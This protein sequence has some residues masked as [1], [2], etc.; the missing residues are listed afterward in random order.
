ML[1]DRVC[2]SRSNDGHPNRPG[3][4][5]LGIDM[6]LN[7]LTG[8]KEIPDLISAPPVVLMVDD[9]AMVGEAMRRMLSTESDIRFH[10]CTNPLNAIEVANE[11]G[12]TV[13]LQ[14]LVMPD[15]D[16]MHMVAQ[17]RANA[18]TRDIPVIVLSSKEDPLIKRDAFTRGANDYLVKLPDPI[19]LIARVRAHSRSFQTQKELLLLQKKLEASNAVLRQ[20]STQ[21]GLTGLA[22]R[23]HFDDIVEREWRRCQRS[24]KQMSLIMIDIDGFKLYND[25]YGH[26]GGDD[27]L[28]MVA[29]ALK[30]G[31]L[32]GGD[33]VARYG[34]EEFAI[35]LPETDTQGAA[36]VGERLREGVEDLHLSH[37]KSPCSDHVTI[38]VGVATCTPSLKTAPERLIQEADRALYQAKRNGRNRVITKE[39]KP[40][41]ESAEAA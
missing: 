6:N 41:V 28:R 11:V 39:L 23:R 2:V 30:A 18:G 17:Y 25:H 15:V 34:G 13:I 16:G 4:L 24:G 20:L 14:D 8:D 32:R 12:A 5:Q 21:D 38:S 10:F 7:E 31:M 35:I 22:N 26:Q 40:P 37:E 36:A 29:Q 9:Q 3:P 1:K 19:E 33:T 27:C